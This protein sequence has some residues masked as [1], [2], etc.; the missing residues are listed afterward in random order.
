M[1][2]ISQMCNKNP[3]LCQGSLYVYEWD[4]KGEDGC[5]GSYRCKAGTELCYQDR[6]E[7]DRD[8]DF[9]CPLMVLALQGGLKIL[10]LKTASLWGADKKRGV[11]KSQG[12][13]SKS[14]ALFTTA[15]E[16]ASAFC[17]PSGA[18][19]FCPGQ[20][21]K[22]ILWFYSFTSYIK[23]VQVTESLTDA[24]DYK[25]VKYWSLNMFRES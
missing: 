17:S 2:R 5:T 9:L 11:A 20:Q 8:S 3:F 19:A 21:I 15:H 14:F 23:T 18:S 12:A 16:N 13:A 4:S 1:L 22:Q 24:P 7:L 6:S 25:G 10:F